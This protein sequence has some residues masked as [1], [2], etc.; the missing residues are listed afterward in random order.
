M[1]ASEKNG[2]DRN[3]PCFFVDRMKKDCNDD[4]LIAM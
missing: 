4:D 2:R 1:I 3:H